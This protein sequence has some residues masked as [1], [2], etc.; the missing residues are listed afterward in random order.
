MIPAEAERLTPVAQ[1]RSWRHM[2]VDG[3]VEP[4]IVGGTGLLGRVIPLLRVAFL[5]VGAIGPSTAGAK[6]A[7]RL[8]VYLD[9]FA[10]LIEH[11]GAELG[12]CRRQRAVR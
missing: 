9:D 10:T 11:V 3:L 4:G 12:D 2:H 7:G 8:G 6:V 1:A 5:V